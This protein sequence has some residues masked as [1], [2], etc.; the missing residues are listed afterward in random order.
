M[1]ELETMQRAK[2]YLDKLA[3]GINP[4]TDQP[5]PDSDCINQVRISRCLFYVSDVLRKVIENGGNIGKTEKIKKQPFTISHE[6][7]KSFRLS[8]TPIPVSEITKR[9]NE[10]VAESAMTKLKY[11]S[12][13]SF[14]LQSGFLAQAEAGD[15]EKTKAPTKQ[16]NTIGITSEERVGQAGTYRVTVYNTEAQ[17][18]ILDNIDAIIE[19]NNQ[20]SMEPA[21]RVEYQGQPWTSTYDET[22]VDLFQKNVPIPEIAITLKRTESGVR[23]RLKKLGL[24]DKRSDAN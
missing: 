19:I 12:I 23:A 24:I 4:L 16:G 11:T 13:T 10:L 20:K 7:L 1:T 2:M 3:N 6:T 15:G 5:A 9:I 8:S 14:L 21:T 17:Q 18:F 22:L